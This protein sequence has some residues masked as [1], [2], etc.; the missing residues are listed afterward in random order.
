MEPL[1]YLAVRL[2][3]KPVEIKIK[4][5]SVHTN[6]AIIKSHPKLNING[7]KSG[8]KCESNMTHIAHII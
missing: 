5:N 3:Q 8:G 6:G 1:F 7:L 4:T 2:V